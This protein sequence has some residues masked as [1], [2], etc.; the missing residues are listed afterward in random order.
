LAASGK[1]AD[2]GWARGRIINIVGDGSSGKTLLALEAAFWFFQNMI[3]KTSKNFPV[4]K[5]LTIIYDNAE[6]VMDFLLEQMYGEDF[7]NFVTWNQNSETVEQ[8]GRNVARNVSSLKD[9]E[10]LLY[11][12]DTLDALVPAEGKKRFLEAAKSDKKEDATYGTEKAKYLSQSFFSNLCSIMEGKDATLIIISQVRENINVM[13]GEK[14]HRAGGKA[15]DFYTHQVVW[16]AEMEKLKKTFKGHERVYGIRTKAKFKRNKTAKP[17]REAELILLFDYGLDDVGTNIAW[18]FGP[19]KDSL[20][21]KEQE[22]S[23]PDLIQLFERN[24]E[25]R[26]LLEQMIEEEWNYI[27][28]NIKPDRKPRF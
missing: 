26:T 18:L 15:L 11:I 28:A 7:V 17:F 10:A 21:W 9:G 12:T 13:F 27:E 6:R 16:L 4:V 23:R 1:G 22:Y 24:P 3:G 8:W 25:E 14:Y 20:I 19:K 2:G 5:N